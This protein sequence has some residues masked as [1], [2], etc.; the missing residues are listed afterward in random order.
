MAMRIAIPQ[1]QGRVSP[2]FDVAGNL[3]LVEV[4]DTEEVSR[5]EA[6]LT[7]TDP[8]KRAHQVAQFSPDVLICGAISWPLEVALRSAGVEVIPQTCGEVDEVLR[9]FLLGGLESE[10]FRMPG[11]CGRRR[12]AG[13]G[14]RLRRRYRDAQTPQQWKP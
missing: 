4:D 13:R 5:V 1:W 9:S 2:V 6:A 10:M 8:T 3:L 7:A 11:C 14:G 12:R